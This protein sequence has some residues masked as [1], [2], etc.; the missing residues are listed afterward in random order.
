MHR[1]TIPANMPI[2]PPQEHISIACSDSMTLKLVP[3]ISGSINT[4]MKWNKV[5][6]CIYLLL[7]Q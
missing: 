3:N 4:Q 5:V 6:D 2:W 1:D 7:I